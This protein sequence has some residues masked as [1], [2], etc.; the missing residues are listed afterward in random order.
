MCVHVFK[1][2]ENLTQVLNVGEAYKHMGRRLAAS[3]DIFLQ[4]RWCV[5]EFTLDVT[6]SLSQVRLSATPWTA[7][8]QL[9]LSFTVSRSLLSLMCIEPVM[10]SNNLIHCSPHLL[11]PSNLPS[12]R[13]FNESA[14]CITTNSRS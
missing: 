14:L 7:A 6:Q 4:L 12:I 10:L 9:S 11:L 13:V 2:S 1:N 8:H 5:W 3:K